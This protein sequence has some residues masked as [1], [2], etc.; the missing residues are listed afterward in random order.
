MCGFIY[1]VSDFPLLEPLL[2]IAG[3]DENDIKDIIREKYL[4][5][6]DIVINLVPSRTGPRLLGAT[7]W[8]ATK[9]DG[10]P[11]PKYASFNSKAGKLMTSPMHTRPPRSIRSVVPASGFCEWQPVFKGGLTYTSLP[12]VTAGMKLPPVIQKK[13][14]LIE[15]Q[16]TPLMLLGSVSKLRVDLDGQPRVN[17]SVITLPPHDGFLDIHH[18]SFPLVLNP[19]EL[20]AWLDPAIPHS[21]FNHLFEQTTF[22]QSFTATEV[23]KTC[24]PINDNCVKIPQASESTD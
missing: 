8:L 23:D 6:T 10:S 13:Q 18:K 2:D 21:E 9:P 3:Y 12:G 22:R 11:D 5:P 4:H 14:F 20:E 7:W 15:Q 16:D 24:Q 19:D 1:N 17:T